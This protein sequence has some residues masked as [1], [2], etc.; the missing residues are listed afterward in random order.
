MV[1]PTRV[2]R[3][4]SSRIDRADGPLADHDVELEVLHR[5]VQ[6]L[7][8]GPGEAMDL[9][10]E[11]DVAVVEVGEDGGEVTGA[12][13]R[14][15]AGDPEPDLHLGG[16]DPG[17]ARLAQAGRAGEE[18]VVDGLAAPGAEQD[19]EM[20][21]QPRLTDELVEPAG[22]QRRLL[23]RLH[24]V[25]AARSSSSGRALPRSRRAA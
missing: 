16:H 7:F 11:E 20:L 23:G 4:R 18:Q 13:Q 22:P 1:A 21:L 6:D 8:D 17:E 2:N 14:R 19:V 24:R 10:D 5:R 25:G 12:L 15:A 3:G 9:V